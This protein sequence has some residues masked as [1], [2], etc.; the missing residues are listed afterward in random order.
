MDY[1]ALVRGFNGGADLAH[2]VDCASRIKRLFL[3]DKHA[4]GL[5][6][7]QLH[8]EIDNPVTCDSEISNLNCVRM[9][10]TASRFGFTTEA[11]DSGLINDQIG[12]ENLNRKFGI[13]VNMSGP[14]D[15]THPT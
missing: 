11:F 7:H 4:Q 8:H 13:N 15:Y 3:V 5:P 10:D 9:V 14:V 12:M 1:P 6:I 2:D